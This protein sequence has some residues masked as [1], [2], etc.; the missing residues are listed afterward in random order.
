[1]KT[2]SNG[3]EDQS[4]FVLH[5]LKYLGVMALFFAIGITLASINRLF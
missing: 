4:S 5:V 3:S 2:Q 1:M